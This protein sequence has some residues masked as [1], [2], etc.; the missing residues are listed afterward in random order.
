MGS[1]VRAGPLQSPQHVT[2]MGH[3]LKTELAPKSTGWPRE[4]AATLPGT[5]PRA[6]LLPCCFPKK[7]SG[8]QAIV[9]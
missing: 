8:T 6:A 5:L 7:G 3:G 9:L 4:Q 2:A 1:R